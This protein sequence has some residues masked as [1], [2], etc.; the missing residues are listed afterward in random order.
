MY[1]ITTRFLLAAAAFTMGAVS[2]WS[3]H[4]IGN[5]SMTLVLREGSYQ[6]S[7]QAGYTFGSLVVAIACMF[8]AFAFV[9][10]SEEV[11]VS[12]IIPSGILAG[13]SFSLFLCL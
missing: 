3:M 6:L 10:V 4:F 11:K 12:R 5:N 8:L 2:I 13:V 7:Y 1:Y 9:G